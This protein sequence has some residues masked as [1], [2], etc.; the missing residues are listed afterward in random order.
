[1]ESTLNLGSIARFVG[2]S[3]ECIQMIRS[4]FEKHSDI[5][6]VYIYGKRAQGDFYIDTPIDLAISH[7]YESQGEID[8]IRTE[9]ELLDILYEINLIDT[10]LVRNQQLKNQIEHERIPLFIRNEF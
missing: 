3:V 5:Q 1:M 2:I 10:D 6:E 9:L 4:V 7:S 8:T